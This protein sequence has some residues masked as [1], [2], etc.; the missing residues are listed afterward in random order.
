MAEIKDYSVTADDNNSASPN[1]MPENMAPSGVNNSWRESF[2]R[3]KRWYEDINA[4]K[5]TTGSS[6]AYVLAAARTVTAYAQGD[7]YMF[8]ANHANTG[9]ATLN[10][11]SVG[12]VAIVNNTQSA[13]AAGQIQAGGIY[14]VAYDATN[15]KF[16]LVGASATSASGD[17][18]FVFNASPSVTL[19]NST[20]EDSDGGRESTIQWKGL[21]SGS[22]E[23]TLVKI[24]GS[25]DGSSDDQKGKLQIYTNDGS[26]GDSPTLQ[27]TIDSAGLCTLVGAASVGGSLTVAGATQLNSTVTVGANDQGYDVILYGDTASANVTWDT[28]VDDLILNGA[29]GLIVPDGQL[30]LGSTAVTSTGAELNYNDTGA[31]VGT[32]VASK[33]VTVDANKDVSSFRNITLTGE[34]DA[35]SLD[36]SGN[37]DI[38]GTLEADAITLNGTA[39]GSLYSPIAGSSSIVTTGALNSGSITSGFGSIDNGSSAITTTGVITGGTVEATTDTAAGDNAAI[40]YTSA[41]GLILTGEGSLSDVTIK[42]DADAT[43]ISIPTGTTKVGIGTTTAENPLTIQDIG[44]STFNRDFA[45]RNGD[46]SNYHRLVLGYNAAS[47]ASGVPTNAQFV[48]AEKGG[49][50][51]TSAGLVVGNSDN[52]PVM[53]TTNAT[54]RFRILADGKVGIGT[55]A[56][57]S[58]V[59]ISSGAA[60]TAK[61]ATT[62][63]N[64]YAE[65]IFEDG[66]AGYG[67]QVRSDGAQS[68]ATG[69]MVIN[70]RDT[71]SFPV[72]INEGNASNTLVLSG[73]KVG[74]GTSSNLT[75]YVNLPESDYGEGFN[76]FSSGTAGNRGG[77][78][79]YSYESRIYYGSSDNLTFVDGGPSG[80]ERMRIAAD[81]NVAIGESSTTAKLDVH[82]ASTCSAELATATNGHLFVAQSDDNTD[83][84][85]IYQKHGSNT[86]RMSFVVN[87]NRTGSKSAA[88]SVRGDGAVAV[89]GAL[90]KGSG[91][92]KIDHPL[93][94]KKDTHYLAHSFVE[95]PQADNIYRGKV[96]LV[97]GTATVNIDT[98][99][100]L[101]EGTFVALNRDIQCFTTNE[102]G[103][104][105]VKGSVSGNVLTINA[106]D[107][108]CADTISWLVIG[109]RQDIHMYE[110]DWTDKNGKVITEPLKEES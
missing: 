92:F 53:F 57:D 103:W 29:A 26:D 63:S 45:I 100:N 68:I 86:T 36:V 30:T 80:T 88:F 20:A 83:A 18:I 46:A 32:V 28:S 5:S 74:V 11:D 85:E 34:L 102:T 33:T 8:R 42:N 90:S 12:A 91:S 1:G 109:E 105:A 35:G 9:A 13:L 78:G 104:T 69:S 44:G 3:V 106:Q 47:A 70:D 60:T 56:P 38:D 96:N 87:D 24:I 17:N 16:Q 72:V 67:F 93:E 48:L 94:S 15:S 71:G 110:V 21:Q 40:G 97:N 98:V 107:H 50:Y 95:G 65:L 84:F 6:N 66:N 39:L 55:S 79:H 37:A 59:E 10:I 58:L 25:H 2:A 82:K 54:E 14:L 23:S 22:E 89:A 73:S 31:A 81:G 99:A 61:I 108:T 43:V 52:A 7:A 101:T 49:G 51:G 77:I 19:E 75:G 41:E 27:V 64:N 4:T 76:W 62:V